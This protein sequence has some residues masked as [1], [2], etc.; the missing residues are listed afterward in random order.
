MEESIINIRAKAANYA[1][2]FL[3]QKYYEEYSELYRAYLAN[4][5]VTTRRTKT[6]LIDERKGKN[7]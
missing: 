1:R 6:T 4:R 5:G 7:A 2:L 3:A